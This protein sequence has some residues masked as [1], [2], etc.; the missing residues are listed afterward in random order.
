[1]HPKVVNF[2]PSP[3]FPAFRL[4]LVPLARL[5]LARISPTD[6]ES[7]ASTI[8]PQG[9][10]RERLSRPRL[11]IQPAFSAPASNLCSLE[12]SASLPASTVSSQIGSERPL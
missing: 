5:E 12:C 7:V 2:C 8:P 1:M 10:L 4:D 11:F 6:F 9:H 3:R